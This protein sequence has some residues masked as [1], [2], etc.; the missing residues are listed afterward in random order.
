[1]GSFSVKNVL[2]PVFITIFVTVLGAEGIVIGFVDL[3]VLSLG[4]SE[5]YI[6]E[7]VELPFPFSEILVSII[8]SPE[9]HVGLR[10]RILFSGAG[11]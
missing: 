4:L 8:M 10:L 7:N 2:K 3:N 11:S 9:G 6:T 5:T 1:L